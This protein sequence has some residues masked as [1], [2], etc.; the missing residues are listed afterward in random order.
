MA[1]QT[2]FTTKPVV[3]C[4]PLSQFCMLNGVYLTNNPFH[5]IFLIKFETR[6]GISVGG[7]RKGWEVEGVGQQFSKGG[8]IK[9]G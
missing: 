8:G 6:F 7:K 3:A 5:T 1:F 4:Q 2:I 9:L